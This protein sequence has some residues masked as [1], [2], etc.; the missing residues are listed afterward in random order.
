MCL[1][2]RELSDAGATTRFELQRASRSLPRQVSTRPRGWRMTGSAFPM[3]I[4][5]GT[6]YSGWLRRITYLSTEP[7]EGQGRARLHRTGGWRMTGSAFARLRGAVRCIS[8]RLRRIS[9]FS[10]GEVRRG[11]VAP[12][13][14]AEQLADSCWSILEAKTRPRRAQDTLATMLKLK[15][16]FGRILVGFSS[17]LGFKNRPKSSKN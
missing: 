8:E 12:P 17:Q 16:D 1:R 15:L 10:K 11:I 5:R 7:R 3:H 4:G 13:H 6:L 9:Y 2:E 14:R